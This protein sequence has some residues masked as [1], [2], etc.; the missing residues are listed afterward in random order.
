MSIPGHSPL[1]R[2]LIGNF[3]VAPS[4]SQCISLYQL[5]ILLPHH[6]TPFPH[7]IAFLTALHLR[8]LRMLELQFRSYPPCVE[9]C[10]ATWE[11]LDLMLQTPQYRRLERVAVLE[12]GVDT[13]S[14]TFIWGNV[15]S[16]SPYDPVA[17]RQK[18]AELL[19]LTHGQRLLF[20]WDDLY[21]S[22][23]RVPSRVRPFLPVE[24]AERIMDFIAGMA[25]SSINTI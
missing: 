14:R 3:T 11:R 17:C 24:V 16:D 19:P 1:T 9:S 22:P 23:E 21:G 20:Y 7:L 8:Q 4:I 6:I 12:I 2:R 18:M 5:V 15:Y 13:G 10:V 25:E